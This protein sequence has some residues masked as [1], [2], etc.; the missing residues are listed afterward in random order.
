MGSALV[1]DA[2]TGKVGKQG[3]Y[4]D[5]GGTVFEGGHDG[6][7]DQ[8]QRQE[9]ILNEQGRYRSGALRTKGNHL[10]TD[11]RLQKNVEDIGHC[12]DRNPISEVQGYKNQRKNQGNHIDNDDNPG[13]GLVNHEANRYKK[14]EESRDQK[15]NHTLSPEGG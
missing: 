5:G 11:L 12:A 4:A 6:N 9:R 15:E 2:E 8:K 13:P 14:G 7:H 3:D 1:R 10:R